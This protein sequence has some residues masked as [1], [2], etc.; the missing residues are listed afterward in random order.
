MRVGRHRLASRRGRMRGVQR[1]LFI[2][3]RFTHSCFRGVLCGRTSKGTVTVSCFHRQ[4]VHSS[5]IGG[6]RLKCDA[7]TP[8]T[9]TRRTVQGKC[10]GRFLLGAKLY[11]RGRS[12]D[13]HSHF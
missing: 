2:I 9:L 11:C 12:N 1:D 7:A 8:S 4:N 6:F 13:L 5:V 3:G 10:G